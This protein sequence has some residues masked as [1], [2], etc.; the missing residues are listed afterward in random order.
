MATSFIYGDYKMILGFSGGDLLATEPDDKW[1]INS[2]ERIFPDYYIPDIWNVIIQRFFGPDYWFYEWS[3][4]AV[5]SRLQDLM[6]APNVCNSPIMR[7]PNGIAKSFKDS[8]PLWMPVTVDWNDE[9]DRLCK[10]RLFNIK[11]DESE[12]NNIAMENKGKVEE[13]LKILN[14]RLKKDEGTMDLASS[15][16]YGLYRT[17]L[18]AITLMLSI[19]VAISIVTMTTLCYCC[20]ICCFKRKRNKKQSKKNRGKSQRNKG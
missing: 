10:V 6:R 4:I 7:H 11:N 13:L 3:F 19:F 2:K 17:F 12:S 9:Y 20:G 8:R 18:K 14:E 15:L 5:M 16:Q 1:T